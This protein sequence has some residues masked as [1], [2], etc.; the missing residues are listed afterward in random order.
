MLLN[1]F[2]L[3]TDVVSRQNIVTFGISISAFEKGKQWQHALWTLFEVGSRRLRHA[4]KLRYS[5]AKQKRYL[6]AFFE[7]CFDH[8]ETRGLSDIRRLDI[9][10]HLDKP[11]SQSQ[12]NHS[13]VAVNAAITACEKCEKW[14]H[15][16][17]LLAEIWRFG[18]QANVV[19][20]SAAISACSKCEEWGKSMGLLQ[21]MLQK[22]LQMNVPSQD[23]QTKKVK[24]KRQ[25]SMMQLFE[26]II[27]N[28]SWKR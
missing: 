19:S 16:L 25:R 15:A 8:M 24:D 11:S 22:E 9:F 2:G 28:E 4:L 6:F 17:L 12:R 14:Q 1:A 7:G 26:L 18:V 3:Q 27:S 10:F 23:R 13:L 20:C 21:D 5:F